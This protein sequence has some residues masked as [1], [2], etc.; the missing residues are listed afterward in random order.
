MVTLDSKSQMIVGYASNYKTEDESQL[1]GLQQDPPSVK[2][3]LDGLTSDKESE[4]QT[5]Q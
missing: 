3:I 1:E 5:E 4:E 2:E